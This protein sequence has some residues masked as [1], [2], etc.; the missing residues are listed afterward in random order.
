MD[1][2]TLVT[3]RYWHPFA[4]MSRVS[5]HELILRRGEGCAIED[6]DGLRHL[7]ATVGHPDELG[8][9]LRSRRTEIAALIGEPVSGVGGTIKSRGR[10]PGGCRAALP[11]P[12]RPARRGGRMT[13]RARRAAARPAHHLPGPPVRDKRRRT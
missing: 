4:A 8:A 11:R 9:L 6:A 3:F 10:L 7:V 5:G 2:S 12:R 13:R 1:S